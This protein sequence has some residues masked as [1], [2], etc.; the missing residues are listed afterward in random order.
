MEGEKGENG[1]EMVMI[2]QSNKARGFLLRTGFVYTFR[3]K[4]R[5]EM[6]RDWI[7]EKRGGKKI[8]N[9]FI[10]K[11]KEIND[12]DDLERYVPQTGF[13][14]LKEWKDEITNMNGGKLPDSGYLYLVQVR[15]I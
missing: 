1:G 3:T 12:I 9:V 13:D 11:I 8:A 15:K 7:N 14:S 5:K 2:F 6:G 10:L 4:K